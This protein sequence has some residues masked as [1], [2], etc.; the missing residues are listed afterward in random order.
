MKKPSSVVT[1]DQPFSDLGTSTSGLSS[2]VTVEG[3]GFSLVQ[4]TGEAVVVSEAASKSATRPVEGPGT[5]VV[6]EQNATQLVEALGAGMTTQPVKT[7]VA[8]PEV[9][10]TSTGNAAMQSN[11]EEDLQSE[12]SSPVDDNFRYGSSDRELNIDNSGDQELS[13]E[14]SCRVTIRSVRSFM[15]WYKIPEFDSVSS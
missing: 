7:P 4:T 14:A 6:S 8:G 11:S 5:D 10:L 2:G 15:G 12:S 13:E 1:S 3:T 9:L